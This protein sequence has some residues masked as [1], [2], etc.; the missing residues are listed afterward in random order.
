MLA[1][2]ATAPAVSSNPLLVPSCQSLRDPRPSTTHPECHAPR[3][4][5][6]CH[7]LVLNLGFADFEAIEGKA[8]DFK[9][10]GD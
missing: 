7:V 6:E 3:T 5:P 4:R 9:K 10:S 2:A 8:Y 1:V